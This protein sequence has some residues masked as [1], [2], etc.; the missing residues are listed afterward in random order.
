MNQPKTKGR[1]FALLLLSLL[2]ACGNSSGLGGSTASGGSGS[3]GDVAQNAPDRVASPLMR[4]APLTQFRK[5]NDWG[6]G[7]TA[8]V[9]I[10]NTTDSAI[11]DWQLSFSMPATIDS[12][13]NATAVGRDGDV[14]R[15]VARSYN[16]VLAPGQTV[17]LGF[18]AS[19]GGAAVNA[20]N[21]AFEWPEAGG[22]GTGSSGTGTSGTGASGGGASG[23][24]TSGSGTS[25]SGSGSTGT[26]APGGQVGYSISSNWGSGFGARIEVRNPGTTPLENWTLQFDLPARIDS[27]WNGEILSRDGNT[28]KVGP[29]SYNRAIPAGGA[30]SFGFNGSPGGA[31]ANATNFVLS[32]PQGPPTSPDP[33]PSPAPTPDPEPGPPAA[34]YYSTSGSRIVDSQGNTVYF[35]GINWFGLETETSSPHGL[36]ARSMDSMLDQMKSLGYDTLRVP[37]SNDA[38]KPGEMARSIDF[39]KNPD[40]QGK[41][42]LEVLDALVAKAGQ[43]DMRIIL[44]R[45]CPIKD[46]QSDLWY[47][48]QVSEEQWISDWE[49]LARRYRGNP[50]VIGADLHNEPHGRATWGSGQITTDWRLAA[51]R[52]GNR[53][54]AANPDWL[55]IVEGVE[56]V[57]GHNYWWGGN[58]RKAGAYPVTLTVPN[59]VVYSTHDYPATVY[60]QSWFAA[61]DYPANMA[62]IWD[63]NWGYLLKQDIAPV[64]VGEFGTRYATQS[65]RIWLAEL[66]DYIKANGAQFTYWCWNENSRDTG[67][68]L[69]GDWR[70]VESA[71]QTALTPLL[72]R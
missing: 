57:D 24:G 10:R 40:L 12:I 37:Y 68:I 56:K 34:G 31:S 32:G 62:A 35:K 71:K 72:Q 44:D 65:D 51:Q 20:T 15:L 70:T 48:S 42:A 16:N 64:L 13:W 33:T 49:M 38:L 63:A 8:E 23:T 29:K 58:L 53:I 45:H 46:V 41:T 30:V 5:I 52:C 36:W 19:P 3:A 6:T 59:K 69:Q 18:N 50:T 39:S 22:T 14:H 1:I 28:Y 47:T 27:L 55:I 25:G 66:V 7:F 21:L 43:R 2:V 67:G 4:A 17:T 61:S 60:E 11:K 54:L 26:S 9:I